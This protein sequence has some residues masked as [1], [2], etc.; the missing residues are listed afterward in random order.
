[1]ISLI[2]TP[3]VEIDSSPERLIIPF[4]SESEI[5]FAIETMLENSA[6]GVT[7]STKLEENIEE[8]ECEM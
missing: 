7:F 1:L 8:Q 3:D 2:I 5:R 4:K 6:S